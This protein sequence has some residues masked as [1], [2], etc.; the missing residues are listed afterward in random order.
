MTFN[1]TI[2]YIIKSDKF[3][4]ERSKIQQLSKY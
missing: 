3:T 4:S 2:N 1:S